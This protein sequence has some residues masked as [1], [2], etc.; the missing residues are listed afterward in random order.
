MQIPVRVPA[1]L[2]PLLAT[3]RR[4]PPAG[5]GHPLAGEDCPVCRGTLAQGVAVLVFAGI[6]AEE[7]KEPPGGRWASGMAVA[8]HALCAGV[9]EEEPG[10]QPAASRP[11]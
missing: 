8:V 10:E 11:A 5:P 2:K 6:E 7:R 4:F 1:G 3:E 9:P